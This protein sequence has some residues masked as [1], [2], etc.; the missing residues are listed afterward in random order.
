MDVKNFGIIKK[1]LVTGKAS[2]LRD[3][4]G[5]FT[6][7]VHK[8]ANKISIKK[9]VEAIW[10][11]EVDAVNVMNCKG[12]NKLFARKPFRSQDMKKAIVTL[13]KGQKIDLPGGYESMGV[14]HADANNNS[15][16]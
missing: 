8:N 6:F 2:G 13:K 12:K 7:Q 14:S 16:K 9:A 4:S 11:V 10:N 3:K 1:V 15:G 5:K